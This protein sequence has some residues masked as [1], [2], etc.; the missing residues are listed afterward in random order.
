MKHFVIKKKTQGENG[1]CA[2]AGLPCDAN[3]AGRL[4]DE[5]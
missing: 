5:L 4:S 2:S 3:N 1:R